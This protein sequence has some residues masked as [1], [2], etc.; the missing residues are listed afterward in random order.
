MAVKNLNGG[1]A[2]NS[3]EQNIG[4]GMPH[5]Q[6]VGMIGRMDSKAISIRTVL[7]SICLRRFQD[8]L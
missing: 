5:V 3:E 2:G 8:I 4:T 6:A 1:S 7:A